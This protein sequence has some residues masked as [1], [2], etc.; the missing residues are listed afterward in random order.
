MKNESYEFPYGIVIIKQNKTFKFY[1]EDYSIIDKW[2]NKLIEC[3]Q[4]ASFE[5]NYI[6]FHDLYL[7]DKTNVYV[8][9]STIDKKFYVAKCTKKD[10]KRNVKKHSKP[11]Y[12]QE[13]LML[14]KLN[15]S[16]VVILYEVYETQE[17]AILILEWMKGGDLSKRLEELVTYSE[18]KAVKLMK[19]LLE[20]LMYLAQN[21]I[22][23][24][25]IKLNNIL[26]QDEADDTT[27]KLA[28]FELSHNPNKTDH[29]L[30]G[31]PG[32]LAPELFKSSPAT[33]KSDIYSA[34]VVLY[35]L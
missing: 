34:G 7:G 24:Q 31:T 18:E 35:T 28:D 27:I 5:S 22:I 16:N 14:Q 15:N 21:Q 6:T 23:H 8:V 33:Y 10:P 12:E 11:Q 1:H 17:Q 20:S 26:L 19:N 30:R 4:Y 3:L 32:Y 29:Y 9:K 13:L 25:D 2:F